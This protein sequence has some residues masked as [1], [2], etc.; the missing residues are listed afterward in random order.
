MKL[1][2]LISCMYQK[3]DSIVALSGITTDALII[4][5]CNENSFYSRLHKGQRI[6]L[7]NTTQRG[8]SNS[9]NMA[10]KNASGDICLFCDDDEVFKSDYEEKIIEAFEKLPDADVITFKISNQPCRLKTR[11][12]KLYYLDLLKIKSWQIAVKTSAVKQ[13]NVYFDPKLGA[14]SENGAQE[15][16]KFLF[17]C[18]KAGLNI[19]YVPE[20]I[21]SVLQESSTWFKGFTKDFFYQ[22]GI[23]TRYIMGFFMS[24]VYAGYYLFAKYPLY[25]KEIS[26]FSAAKAIFMGIYTNELGKE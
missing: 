1:E 4:N 11:V 20:I 17:D 15:E 14:G 18:R 22:R 25:C 21:A 7:A 16:N 8:L 9:R 23:T 24:V 26:F 10:L 12:Q 13:A 19:Y 3:D 2:V 5:Q 6:R